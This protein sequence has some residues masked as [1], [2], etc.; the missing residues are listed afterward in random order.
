[1]AEILHMIDATAKE[2]GL[3]VESIRLTGPKTLSDLEMKWVGWSRV[4]RGLVQLT[5]INPSIDDLKCLVTRAR[6]RQDDMPKDVRIW[7]GDRSEFVPCCAALVEEGVRVNFEA[8]PLVVGLP[9]EVE[10]VVRS[11]AR[12]AIGGPRSAAGIWCP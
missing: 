7:G 3:K 2:C 9:G 5:L 4:V 1:M 8:K 11:V 6:K 12:S 10:I